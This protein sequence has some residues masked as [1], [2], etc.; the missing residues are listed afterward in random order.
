MDQLPV[1]QSNTYSRRR[2]TSPSFLLKVVYLHFIF[3]YLQSTLQAEDDGSQDPLFKLTSSQIMRSLSSCCNWP[4]SFRGITT[5]CPLHAGHGA[6]SCFKQHNQADRRVNLV[7]LFYEETKLKVRGVVFF[8]VFNWSSLLDSVM[9]ADGHSINK[10]NK[11]SHLTNKIQ[12]NC[13]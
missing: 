11:S 7:T 9:F 1:L 5:F 2:Q 12:R 3:L 8:V 4:R 13:I 6:T 10:F